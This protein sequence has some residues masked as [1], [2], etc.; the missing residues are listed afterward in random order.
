MA[1]KVLVAFCAAVGASSLV[2][3]VGAHVDGC[4]YHGEAGLDLVEAL[5]EGGARVA[6]PTT[7]NVG[8]LDL[9]HPELMRLSG[10]LQVGPRR[11]MAAHEELGCVPPSP[12]RPIRRCFG[13]ISA[14]RSHGRNCNAIVFANSVIGARTER[15]GD[16]IDLCCAITGRRAGLRPAHDGEPPRPGP[17]RSRWISGRRRDRS[18]VRG[19]GTGHRHALRRSHSGDRGPAATASEDQLKALGAAAARP[20]LWAVPCGRASRRKRPIA[21]CGVAGR[22]PRASDP[23]HARRSARGIAAGFRPCP[24]GRRLRP[25]SR[26]AAFFVMTNGSGC[27]R[28]CAGPR[29][30]R[31]PLCQHRPC[32]ARATAAR[33]ARRSSG[34]RRIP[35]V[36]TCT[37]V[38]AILEELD[39]AVMT[40]SGKWA[41][42]APGNIGCPVAFGEL[43]DCVASIAA[44]RIVRG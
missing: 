36:D 29:R 38:T 32:D 9:I 11:L 23:H 26:H 22:M 27:C 7:L 34:L 13:R 12:A 8:S 28:C 41:H 24:T 40:N 10:D 42:Y 37:Y 18:P 35:V 5:L 1:M 33:G 2:A 16:F 43:E 39:G 15:Y 44:G 6:V 30:R 25:L 20:A 3:I 21:R 4:L 31:L 19:V 17:V 14:I